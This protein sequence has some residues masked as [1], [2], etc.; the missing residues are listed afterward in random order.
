MA[1]YRACS[2]GPT[3]GRV[4]RFVNPC[5][6]PVGAP[7]FSR[8]I[9]V[10]PVRLASLDLKT[11][12]ITRFDQAGFTPQWVDRGFVTLG[13]VDGS[14]IALPFDAAR[15]RPTGVPV[16]I[17]RDVLT[18]DALT[19]SRAAV[20]ASGTIVFPLAGDSLGGQL[21]LVSRSGGRRCW[22]ASQ[23]PSTIR[24]SRPAGD[25]VAVGIAGSE[26][27]AGRDV[28]ILNMAQRAWSRLTTNGISDRPIWTPD[29]RRIVY[30]SNSDLWWIAADGSGHPDSLFVENG[31][32]IPGSVTPDG[33]AVVFLKEGSLGAG[34]RALAFDSAPAASTV[35]P[36][37]FNETAPACRPMDTGWHINP[38]KPA[39][40]RC[41]FAPIRGPVPRSRCHSWAGQSRCGPERA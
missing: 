1:E 6:C 22:R 10:L 33:R 38:T 29:G 13:S 27:G 19:G 28:W 34:I 37:R 16:T 8:F 15:A 39:G 17:A 11:G 40:T 5:C 14:L 32:H 4:N 31:I 3:A 26:N 23:G 18:P 7:C 30:S 24:A 20:S 25:R 2:P 35:M 21:V 36:A 12:E 41:M 9:P